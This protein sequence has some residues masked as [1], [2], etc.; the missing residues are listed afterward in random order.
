MA[1]TPHPPKSI[2][3]HTLAYDPQDW[4]DEESTVEK[5]SAIL[6]EVAVALKGPNEP[7]SL[8]SW[9]DLAEIARKLKAT[10]P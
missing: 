1:P 8:H 2:E 5:L 9:H 10:T 3:G 4:A 6:H 7:L